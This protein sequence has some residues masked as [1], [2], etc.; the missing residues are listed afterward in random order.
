MKALSSHALNLSM[1]TVRMAKI[2]YVRRTMNGLKPADA[3]SEGVI[4]E[5]PIG[6]TLKVTIT[7]PRNVAHHR[8]FFA[9]LN[10]IYENQS[11]YQSLDEL[12]YAVKMKLGYV[13]PVTIKG[14][15][16]FMPKSISFTSM[17]QSAF[18]EFYERT[19]DFVATEIIPGLDENDLARELEGF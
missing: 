16:G 8:K 1:W 15:Q 7:Q 17:D 10:I 18:S 6:Q 14:Q 13:I 19:V 11:H 3:N 9:M 12:L 5:L 4:N 2:A